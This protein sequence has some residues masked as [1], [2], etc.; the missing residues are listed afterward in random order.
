MALWSLFYKRREPGVG[1]SLD[2]ALYALTYSNDAIP[3]GRH[4]VGDRY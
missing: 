4:V 2:M 1:A 3:N